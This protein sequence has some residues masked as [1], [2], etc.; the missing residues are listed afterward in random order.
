MNFKKTISRKNIIN[1]VTGLFIT[2]TLITFFCI[3]LS[4]GMLIDDLFF[5]DPLDFGMDFYN[6]ISYVSTRSPY[7]GYGTLYSPFANFIYYVMYFSIRNMVHFPETFLEGIYFRGTSYDLRIFQPTNLLYFIYN[8]IL[9]VLL[10]LMILFFLK[11]SNS[12]VKYT[13]LGLCMFSFGM[14]YA[15]ER[16]NIIVLSF[17][18]VFFFIAFYDSSNKVLKEL[19]LIALAFA[20]GLKL[21]PAI[22]GLLLLKNKDYSAAFRCALY[23]VLTIVLPCF[24]LKE[25]ISA[26]PK[27]V[28]VVVKFS[29]GRPE[30][31]GNT[32]WQI[33]FLIEDI[34]AIDFPSFLPKIILLIIVPLL[35]STFLITNNI[36]NNI[37]IVSIMLVVFTDQP[38]YIYVFYVIPLI[39]LLNS[40]KDYNIFE[41]IEIFLLLFLI[42]PLP[43]FSV[44]RYGL[45]HIFLT[46]LLIFIAVIDAV[47]CTGIIRD[48]GLAGMYKKK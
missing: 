22:F 35:M 10:V 20:F 26:I 47:Y 9:I 45:V 37:L 41:T 8:L 33:L 27:W 1:W 44:L 19:S 30:F 14:L 48:V 36:K 43:I 5:D 4:G 13:S 29:G 12:Y 6:S 11:K 28:N 32:L 15:F 18:F 23:G 16:G 46:S 39:V 2:F 17:L 40:T 34:F 31:S 25:G 21:Y 7:D 42:I 24:V 3:F 38:S